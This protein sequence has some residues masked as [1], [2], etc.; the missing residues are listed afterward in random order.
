M[1]SRSLQGRSRAHVWLWVKI[2]FLETNTFSRL[3]KAIRLKQIKMNNTGLELPTSLD[4]LPDL[5][6]ISEGRSQH[7]TRGVVTPP[8]SPLWHHTLLS[9]CWW[10][11]DSS[12]DNNL[13]HLSGG[14]NAAADHGIIPGSVLRWLYISVELVLLSHSNSNLTPAAL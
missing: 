7:L 3:F 11:R 9:N 4:A 10:S 13:H 2:N 8:G 5:P 1:T 6:H 14:F 12:N